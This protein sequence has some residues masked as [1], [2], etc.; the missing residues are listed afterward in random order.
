MGPMWP[1]L[2]MYKFHDM[3]HTGF[4]RLTMVKGP[5]RFGASQG[6]RK[7][8]SETKHIFP[9]FLV[10]F[11]IVENK[12]QFSKIINKQALNMFFLFFLFLRI[13]N[14]FKK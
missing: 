2:L 11:I 13:E 3:R 6:A 14:S 4:R 7:N 1:F 12:K 10:I 9:F 8:K 5:P